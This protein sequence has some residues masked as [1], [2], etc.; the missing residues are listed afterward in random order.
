[1][2]IVTG[3]AGFIGSNL[4]RKLN[5]DRDDDILLVE[6]L[7]NGHKIKNIADL[8]I[9][10]Y[11]DKDDF[12]SLL[13][14]SWE[15]TDVD[16][17]FHLG[18]C[19]DT[20]EWDGK[21]MMKSNFEYS[22]N[23]ASF[24]FDKGV[25][26][27]YASSGAVYGSQKSFTEDSQFEKPLNIYGYS[28]LLF[29][30]YVGTHIKKSDSLVV[31]LRYFNVYGRGEEFKGNMSS[32]IPFFNEQLKKTG[33]IKLFEGSHGYGPG[34][35]SRD[36]IS[37]EDVVKVTLWFSEQSRAKSGI[38]NCGTGHSTTFQSVAEAVIEWHGS[39]NIEYITFPQQL[40]D[41]YQPFTRA[42][43]GKLRL[44]G[45]SGAFKEITQGVKEYLTWLNS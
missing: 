44:A 30:R 38:Y 16:C 20:M 10:D 25:P 11:I 9:V 39:G 21:Y 40:I 28:K 13:Q 24:C 31:G 32:V 8:E 36:F 15:M 43:L 19:V 41:S 7:S 12:S 34:L 26:L 17:I 33:K 1:M 4:I 42:D 5:S 35:Q 45:Y 37:V 3:G 22:K 23:L 2:I 6:D 27:V 14:S 18:A 29:D